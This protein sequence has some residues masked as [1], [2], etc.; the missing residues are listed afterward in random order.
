MI[1]SKSVDDFMARPLR[2]SSKAKKVKPSKIRKALKKAGRDWHTTPRDAQTTCLALGLKYPGYLFF[3]GMGGGK[4]LANDEPVLMADGSWKPIGDVRPGDLIRSNNEAV[5]PVLAVH[6][7]GAKELYRVTFSNGAQTVC[8]L[9]HLW[10]VKTGHSDWRVVPTEQLLNEGLHRRHAIPNVYWKPGPLREFETIEPVGTGEATCIT[11]RNGLFVTRDFI[12][13]HNT[14]LTYD[15]YGNR[16]ADGMQG[17][18]LVLVPNIV[19]LTGWHKE[20][21]KHAPGLDVTIIDQS[22]EEGRLD[23]VVNGGDVVV[24][25]YAGWTRLC[26]KPS[27]GRTKKARQ[28]DI[29]KVDKLASH[30][31]MLALDES[32]SVKSK[33]STI[34]KIARRMMRTIPH[35]YCLTGTPINKDPMGFWAQFFL[36]DGGYT[37]GETLGL[38]RQAFFKEEEGYFGST[39]KFDKKKDALLQR[40]VRNLSIRYDEAECQD[41]PDRNGGLRDDWMLTP[42]PLGKHAVK[43]YE[44]VN[45]DLIEARG[46]AQLVDNAYHRMRMLSSGW[47]GAKTEDNEEV[48]IVFPDNP[49]LDAMVMLLREIPEDEKV[50][51]VHYYNQTGKLIH[52]RLK[53]EKISFTHCYG[54][55]PTGQ[56]A[57]NLEKFEDRGGPRVLAPSTAI[58][59]GLN[60][61]E[62]ARYMIFVESPDSY[63]ERDQI[64]ARILREGNLPGKR[65]YFDLVCTRPGVGVDEKIL[66]SLR[67]GRSIHEL[68]VDGKCA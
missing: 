42:V 13:T 68:L 48:Q 61:Q 1:S 17:R 29:R 34:F 67:D 65:W 54:K 11:V 58:S 30:F 59:K 40:R 60:L 51:V 10:K 66:M 18:L 45:A 52:E 9:E 22:G 46:D 64:E 43:H 36:I 15:I 33:D 2:D 8:C 57:K 62:A 25:T 53:K 14:K 23:A 31:G 55:T 7:Q 5:E 49:K 12:V 24:C 20:A 26:T 21:A 4:A 16:R 32:T 35:R 28:M 41:L 50:I 27:N 6:P 47:L 39:W 63:I 44:S 3:L 37:L 19:N 38:F 56:K